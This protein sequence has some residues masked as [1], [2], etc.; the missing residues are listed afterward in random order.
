MNSPA[1]ERGARD[2]PVSSE[3]MDRTAGDRAGAAL[4][5]RP[6]DRPLAWLAPRN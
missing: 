5:L 2:V 4:A 1:E 3:R 6:C